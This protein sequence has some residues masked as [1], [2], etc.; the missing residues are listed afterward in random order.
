MKEEDFEDI[1][2]F[3]WRWK[4]HYSMI[5][6]IS[7]SNINKDQVDL[8]KNQIDSCFIGKIKSKL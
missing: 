5:N 3:I 4:N 7:K 1:E 8:W 2:E 6:I